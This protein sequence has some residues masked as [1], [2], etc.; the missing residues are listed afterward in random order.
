MQLVGKPDCHL[1]DEA[2]RIIAAVCAD[3]GEPWSE[4]SIF[5]DPALAD[6]F[7][8]LIPVTLVDGRVLATW[9]IDEA[10]LRVALT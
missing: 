5:D 3:L 6:Q 7:W 8:E 10:A 2:R 9:T 4:L 1:C